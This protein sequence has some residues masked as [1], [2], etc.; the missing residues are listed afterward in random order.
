MH[1]KWVNFCCISIKLF[2]EGERRC[3]KASQTTTAA[4][5]LRPSLAFQTGKSEGAH[6]HSVSRPERDRTPIR[7]CGPC[8]SLHPSRRETWAPQQ[9]HVSAHPS[10]PAAGLG[11][12]AQEPPYRGSRV[13][14]VCSPV[15]TPSARLSQA[16]EKS[17]P[18]TTHPAEDPGATQGSTE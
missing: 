18:H 17:G 15:T 16:Q 2:L 14:C 8:R 7:C 4:T 9:K 11:L 5:T 12:R 6:P 13:L 10:T 1:F 3:P